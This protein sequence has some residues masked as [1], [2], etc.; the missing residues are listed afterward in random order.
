MLSLVSLASGL[1]CNALCWTPIERYRT[2][3]ADS[4]FAPLFRIWCYVRWR[5]HPFSHLVLRKVAPPEYETVLVELATTLALLCVSSGTR[6]RIAHWNLTVVPAACSHRA[7]SD[8]PRD[9]LVGRDSRATWRSGAAAVTAHQQPTVWQAH[10]RS[11]ASTYLDEALGVVGGG[12]EG[13]STFPQPLR[14]SLA[15]ATRNALLGV[16]DLDSFRG[17]L[18]SCSCWRGSSLEEKEQVEGLHDIG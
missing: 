4:Q 3:N 14:K 10:R 9:S 7:V 11:D 2:G 5:P 13:R 17:Y 18:S 12:S 15:G 16:Y 8:L 1:N 6:I